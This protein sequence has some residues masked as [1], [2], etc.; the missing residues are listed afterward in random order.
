[1]LNEGDIMKTIVVIS[2]ISLVLVIS[3]FAQS[4]DDVNQFGAIDM[5]LSF[6]E[7]RGQFG[8]KTLFRAETKSAKLYFC[9]DEIACLLIRQ[10]DE[11]I[12][13]NFNTAGEE[14]DISGK[15]NRPIYKNEGI[16]FKTRFIGADKS[17]EVIGLDRLGY[18]QNYFLGNDLSGWRPN[19]PNF[20][21]IEYIDIYPG[22]DLK[23]YGNDGSLKYDFIVRPGADI[24]KIRMRYE[25]IED[26]GLSSDGSL[27]IETS[28]GSISELSPYI[29]QA[30][31]GIRSDVGG[32]FE[33]LG[34]NEIGFVVDENYDRDSELIIDP[35]IVFSTYIGGSGGDDIFAIDVDAGGN[36]HAAGHSH[37]PDLPIVEPYD[38]TLTG[39]TDLFVIKINSACDSILYLTYLG[40]SGYELLFDAELTDD[41]ELC[42]GGITSSFDYPTVDPFADYY[43]DNGDSIHDREIQPDNVWHEGASFPYY[44]GDVNMYNGIWPPQRISGDVTYLVGYLRQVITSQ[45]CILTNTNFTGNPDGELWASADAN[46]NCSVTSGDVTKLVSVFR[47]QATTLWCGYNQPDPENYFIPSWL[48]TD[49]FPVDPP[50]GWTPMPNQICDNVEAPMN[51]KV[52]PSNMEK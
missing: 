20:A 11:L 35:Q 10:T 33:I 40:G 16:L 14:E 32:R 39:D 31:N 12:E 29:Y 50:D 49:D 51:M 26:L 21:S 1:M 45:P 47:G 28:F 27:E 34:E 37:S 30:I 18:N 17:P 44:P 36:I 38:S 23:Y 41:A 15:S 43:S 46:G 6:T 22:I 25:G 4:W 52:I 3:G 24:S 42:I 9:H 19:V 5:P 48:T 2:M 13:N 8:G 7:N